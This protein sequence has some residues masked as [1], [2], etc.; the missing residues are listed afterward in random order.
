MSKRVLVSGSVAIPVVFSIK[1]C[2]APGNGFT[3]LD[4]L[5]CEFK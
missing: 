5:I 2:L 3:V 1:F 4:N